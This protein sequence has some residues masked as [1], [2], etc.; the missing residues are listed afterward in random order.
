MFLRAWVADQIGHDPERRQGDDVDLGMAEEPEQV[1]EQDRAAAAVAELLAHLDDRRHEE[2][3]PQHPVEQHHHAGDEQSGEGKQGQDGGGEDP[4]H[5][6]RQAHQR[7][8]ARTALQHG[9]DVVQAAHGEADDEQDEGQ[10]HHD[11]A[12]LAPRRPGQDGLG[13]IEGPAGAG[14]PAGHEEP[15][16]Q[17]EHGEQIDPVAEHVDVGEH[18]VPG[19]DHQRDQVIAEPAQE[20]RGEQIDHHDHAV[21]G[22]ELIVLGRVD[23]RERVREAELQPHQ[24]GQHQSHQ[25]DSKSGDR[26]L[27]GDDLGVL[28]E[29][30]LRPP[31]MGM[32][33]FDV[34]DFR[35]WDSAYCGRCDMGHQDALLSRYWLSPGALTCHAAHVHPPT[36]PA[37]CPRTASAWLP[38]SP[39]ADSCANVCCSR[40]HA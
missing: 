21:H 5:R 16:D 8:P 24:P 12:P 6:Q 29:Y 32:V 22:D 25:A 31:A 1:L 36:S 18:H 14:R 37:F 40:S 23:D 20:Q 4:P 30:V 38:C 26:V 33:E 3:G 28:A 27:D 13:R 34:L 10:E 15:R 7:H 9:H 17:H 11:D 19:A 39:G 35:R 2:A